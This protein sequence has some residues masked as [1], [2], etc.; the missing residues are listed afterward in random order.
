MPDRRRHTTVRASALL[1][2]VIAVAGCRALPPGGGGSGEPLESAA[3]ASG[4]VPVAVDAEA[5]EA[6]GFPPGTPLEYAGRSTTAELDVQ[7]VVGDPMSD[8][9]ADIYITRDAFDQGALHGRLVC[10]I[11]VNDPWFAEV[12]V[13]PADGGRLSLAPMPSISPSPLPSGSVVINTH[14]GLGFVRIEHEGRLWRFDVE[15]YPYNPPDGWSEIEVVQLRAGPNGPIVVGP[16][17]SEWQL[18]PAEPDSSP[19]V[20]F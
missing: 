14:C 10:A 19:R 9:P 5:P 4:A 11:F 20:C 2:V 6:C 12:T 18:I 17:G 1:A 16:D 8:D 15:E 3:S 7:E 13:H